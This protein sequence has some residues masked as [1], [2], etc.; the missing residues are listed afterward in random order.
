[1]KPLAA[2]ALLITLAG[3]FA[4]A[5]DGLRPADL[6]RGARALAGPEVRAAA[7]AARIAATSVAGAAVDRARDAAMEVA[8]AGLRRVNGLLGVIEAAPRVRAVEAKVMTWSGGPRSAASSCAD[9]C[10]ARA[11]AERDARP[12]ARPA[13]AGRSTDAI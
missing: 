1:M 3:S 12:A 10:R 11:G 7:R 9:R 8:L 6:A 2:V 13:G 5:G 4:L